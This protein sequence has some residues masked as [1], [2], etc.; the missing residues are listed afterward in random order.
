MSH[1]IPFP[2]KR[3]D[4]D[5]H[6]IVHVMGDTVDGFEIGHES[7]SGGSWGGFSWYRTGQEAIAAAYAL[8][9]DQY[10]GACD[11]FICDAARLDACP[12]VVLVTNPGE[13]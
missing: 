8:N 13:W 9:R 11:V 6:G 5:R 10:G 1:I 2:L 7:A 12:N 3:P 4:A